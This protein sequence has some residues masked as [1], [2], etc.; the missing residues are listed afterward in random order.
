MSEFTHTHTHK[1][2]VYFHQHDHTFIF[3]L[4][5]IRLNLQDIRRE[6]VFG[7]SGRILRMIL[8]GFNIF[9]AVNH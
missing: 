6:L 7:Y 2:P 4:L 8:F 9:A 1:S 5:Y 3:Q